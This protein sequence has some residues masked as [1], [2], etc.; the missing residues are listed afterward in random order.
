LKIYISQGSVA[1]QL[2]C[3]GIFSNEFTTN[4]PQNVPLKKI[5]KISQYLAKIWTKVCGMVFFGPPC[6]HA[7]R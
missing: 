2:K 6:I 5:L 4:F 1:T 3:A 7:Y